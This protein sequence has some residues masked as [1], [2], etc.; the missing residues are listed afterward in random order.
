MSFVQLQGRHRERNGHPP[1][2]GGRREEG[3]GEG[4]GRGGKG[5]G[6]GGKGG[7]ARGE[8]L[9]GKRGLRA[10]AVVE[11]VNSKKEM[12]SLRS[13]VFLNG[14]HRG[15]FL[16]PDHKL[17]SKMLSCNDKYWPLEERG[18]LR[19]HADHLQEDHHTN[20][21]DKN[22]APSCKWTNL[23]PTTPALVCN[24]KSIQDSQKWWL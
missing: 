19:G 13:E 20:G 24:I 6:G 5:G 10:A 7:E 9:K 3:G 12:D 4:K 16:S 22:R 23:T 18:E 11:P 21:T 1:P 17:V 8:E 2:W 15:D 14:C